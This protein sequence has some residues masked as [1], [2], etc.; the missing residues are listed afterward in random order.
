MVNHIDGNKKNNNVSNLEWVTSS[1]NIKH[2]FRTGL[3]TP[4]R[5]ILSP[6]AKFTNNQIL[7]IR[8]YKGKYTQRVLAKMYNMSLAN[9]NHIIN[10]KTWKNI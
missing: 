1:E 4:P 10:N 2:A 3:M 9:I 8:G 7:E 5:G 6:V